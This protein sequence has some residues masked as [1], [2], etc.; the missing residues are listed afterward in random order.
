M[1]TQTTKKIF[2][3]NFFDILLVVLAVL[4][5]GAASVIFLSARSSGTDATVPVEYTVVVKDI[6][7][8]MKIRTKAGENVYNTIQP[9]NIGKITT[10]QRSLAYYDA[11]NHET[12]TTVHAQY[13]DI[14][15]VTFTVRADAQKTQ[16]YYQ[17]GN[18]KI[19]IG[20]EVHFRTSNFVGYGYVTSVTEL[21]SD[22]ETK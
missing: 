13:S 2:K 21:P 15:N 6:P 1:N 16:S 9:A 5:I 11:F 22:T 18:L 3:L 12:E 17:V 8:Q 20:A 19:G 14:Y 4:V 10:V 7:A